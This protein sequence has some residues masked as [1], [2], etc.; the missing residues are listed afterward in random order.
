[1][2]K[3]IRDQLLG[4]S[5]EE[6][7]VRAV[8]AF[9]ESALPLGR[10]SLLGGDEVE[11][12][13]MGMIEGADDQTLQRRVAKKIIHAQFQDRAWM[14]GN[15]IREAQIT[16]QLEH[17]H[18]VPVHELARAED[19]RVYFTMRLVEGRT[20]HDL[21]HDEEPASLFDLLDIL[22]KVCDALAL[23]HSRGVVHCDLKPQNIM[24]GAFGAVYLMDWGLAYVQGDD[25]EPLGAPDDAPTGRVST[26]VEDSAHTGV[27]GTPAY[28]SPEHARGEQPGKLSDIFSLG[29]VLYHVVTGRAPYQADNMRD[30]VNAAEGGVFE[31]PAVVAGEARVPNELNRIVL[32]AMAKSPEDRYQ[33]VSEIKRDLVRFVRGGGEFPRKSFPAGEHIVR[34]GEAG[35]AAYVIVSG[36][37]E[38]YKT[39]DGEKVTLRSLG[40]GQGFGEIAILASRPR[41]ASVVCEVDT[42]V[43]VVTSQIIEKEVDHMKPWM[44]AFIR[45]LVHL[46]EEG[47]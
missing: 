45:N 29:A 4:V 16:A 35:D 20:L 6:E 8:R 40:P 13:G 24:T 46:A 5:D 21:I 28:M 23:A 9:I 22:I 32:R 19:G 10:E 38:V 14:V 3:H 27:Y 44:G 12:G 30:L 26:T 18:I 7:E 34:E 17:P 25:F 11:R 42:E 33:S 43:M 39:I 1:M 47:A 15:F 41:T 37:C 2:W 36:G 31:P